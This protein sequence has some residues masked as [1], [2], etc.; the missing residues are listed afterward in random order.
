LVFGAEPPIAFFFFFFFVLWGVGA[1][2]GPL[3]RVFCELDP[4]FLSSRV[5]VSV[6]LQCTLRLSSGRVLGDPFVSLFSLALCSFFFFWEYTSG[7]R[8][9]K[10]G[11]FFVFS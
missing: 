7:R 9:L 11:F 3:L 2:G 8:R 1:N 6:I 4:F 10:F 5:K